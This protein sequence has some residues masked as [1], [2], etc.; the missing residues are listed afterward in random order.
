MIC[1]KMSKKKNKNKPAQ[2]ALTNLYGYPWYLERKT[3]SSR[4]KKMATQPSPHSARTATQGQASAH[5]TSH[6]K[7]NLKALYNNITLK[8]VS[9]IN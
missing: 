2:R 5:N 6:K 7:I 8:A 3:D 1:I 9:E 4:L